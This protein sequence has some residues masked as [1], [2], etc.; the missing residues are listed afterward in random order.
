MKRMIVAAALAGVALSAEAGAETLTVYSNWHRE[1]MDQLKAEFESLHPEI[2]LEYFRAA[3]AELSTQFLSEMQFG[4]GRADYIISDVD[5]MEVFKARG[6]L[7]Q[8]APDSVA[9]MNPAAIDEDGYWIPIDFSPYVMVYNARAVGEDVPTA[10]ADML[11][12]RFTD[13]IGI[14][15]PRTS[16]GV[17]VPLTFWTRTLAD[18][19]EPYGVG[20][21]EKLGALNPILTSGHRQL[22]DLVVTG[23]IWIAAEMPLAFVTPA[24]EAGEPIGIVWPEEGSPTSPN[25]GAIVAETDSLEAAKLLHDYLASAEGQTFLTENWGT[26][27]SHNDVVFTT[28][29]GQAIADVEIV[30]VQIPAEEREENTQRFLTA[31]E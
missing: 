7:H 8:Y 28:P 5:F 6:Y 10:W 11:D 27:P 29:D 15:D 20:F 25:A 23:E 31:V 13:R 4:T 17:Q 26:V 18:R 3:G 12:E 1:A 21:L 22:V 24:V 9:Q 16:A 2:T 30:R 14:A 19:G